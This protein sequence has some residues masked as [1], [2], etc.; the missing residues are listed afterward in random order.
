M[1]GSGEARADTFRH[2]DTVEVADN[3][4]NGCGANEDRASFWGDRFLCRNVRCITK[5]LSPAVELVSYV[6]PLSDNGDRVLIQKLAK[7]TPAALD[8][9][10]VV[11]CRV[12]PIPKSTWCEN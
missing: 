9:L 10:G 4:S 11:R 7:L 8:C 12:C 1:H 6:T 2:I 5:P 3:D